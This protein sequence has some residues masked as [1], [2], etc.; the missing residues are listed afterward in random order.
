MLRY[1]KTTAHHHLH[2]GNSDSGGGKL[3]G[4]TDSDWANDSKDHKSQGGHVFII[5]G[6]AVPWQSRKQDL[7]A[8]STLEA[9]YIACSEASR[10]ARWLQQLQRDIEDQPDSHIDEPLPIH[11]DSQGALAHITTGI[12]KA[13]TKHIDVCYHNFRDL[14]AREIIR[15]DYINTNDNPTDNLTKVL[16]RKEHEKFTRA[17][18]VRL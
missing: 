11:T 12:T 7:V 1:L 14:H 10:E 18:G 9:E 6:G 8:V 4:Y 15:Y 17:I 5:N 2:F 16:P 13:R 3:A